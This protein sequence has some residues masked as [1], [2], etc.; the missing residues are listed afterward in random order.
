MPR[1][2]QGIFNKILRR[3]NELCAEY[4]RVVK[5]YDT[6]DFLDFIVDCG[7]PT[8]QLYDDIE[9]LVQEIRIVLGTTKFEIENNEEKY[10]GLAEELMSLQANIEERFY[11]VIESIY[12]AG[13]LSDVEIRTIDRYGIWSKRHNHRI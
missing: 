11:E 10:K 8:G 6:G 7:H 3:Y 13:G 12:R 2:N 4:D 9:K 1:I 5:L